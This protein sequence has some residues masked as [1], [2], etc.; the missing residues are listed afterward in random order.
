MNSLVTN[1]SGP[2]CIKQATDM[3]YCNKTISNGYSSGILQEALGIVFVCNASCR[4]ERVC[5]NIGII[6][7]DVHLHTSKKYHYFCV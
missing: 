7:D 2:L 5:K 1:M 3:I 6:G 4:R